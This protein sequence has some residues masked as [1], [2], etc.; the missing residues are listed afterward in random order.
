MFG[1]LSMWGMKK[2]PRLHSGRRNPDGTNTESGKTS[3]GHGY[4]PEYGGTV[5][6][7]SGYVKHCVFAA[8][9]PSEYQ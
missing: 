9:L 2:I 5:A 7:H 6:V 3:G 4:F 8:A 1:P